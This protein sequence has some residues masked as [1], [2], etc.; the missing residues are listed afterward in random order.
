MTMGRNDARCGS[1]MRLA[2]AACTA[3]MLPSANLI[4]APCAGF[5]DVDSAS[6]FC[7]SVEWIRNRNVT[8]GCTSSS[9]FCPDAAVTRLSMAA[10]LNRLGTALTPL[11]I[12]AD[13][14]PGP[15]L[16]DANA[17]AC[18]TPDVAAAG[19]PRRAYV[20]ATFNAKAGVDVVF[21]ADLVMSADGGTT[22]SELDAT[23][24]RG[25]VAA[26][27]WGGLADIGYGEIAA[28][29][30]VR[31]G[32]RVSRGGVAGTFDL[33]DSRCKVRALVYSRDGA[34]SPY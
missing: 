20:D 11:A 1:L 27:L 29:Q 7:P 13:Q 8:L 18:A 28:G 31:F 4:A 34:A 25:S 5:A 16:L 15:L 21:A 23:P 30:S 14:Q 17:V 12:G 32:V 22:W 9:A 10:F 3:L 24:N 19:F 6:P 26:N 2:R 33:A